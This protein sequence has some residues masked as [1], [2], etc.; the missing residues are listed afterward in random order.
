MGT[1][2]V[3]PKVV[4]KNEQVDMIAKRLNIYSITVRN[5]IDAYIDYLITELND[6]KP[7]KVLSI[8]YI[9]LKDRQTLSLEG[10]IPRETLAYTAYE[11]SKIVNISSSIVYRVLIEY[12]NYIIKTIESGGRFVIRSLVVIYKESTVN[13][14]G[15]EKTHLRV[16]RSCSLVDNDYL[17]K[18]TPT[19][20]FR[21][22]IEKYDRSNS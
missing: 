17:Y 15:I 8:C 4:F 21:G 19:S 5:I 9:Q 22:L 14:K 3:K 7:V 11:L 1:P 20:Y 10:N 13:Y 12:Q 2:S 16:K 6:L 18:I